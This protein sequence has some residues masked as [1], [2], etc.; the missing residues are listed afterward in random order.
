[1]SQINAGGHAFACKFHSLIKRVWGQTYV[2]LKWRGGR[3]V[4]ILKT[5]SSSVCENFRGVLISDHLSKAATDILDQ[6]VAPA[7]DKYVPKE[8]CGASADRGSDLAS[9]VVRTALDFAKHHS[10]SIAALFLDITKAFDFVI[11]ELAIG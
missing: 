11:R 2:P 6:D 8:Q 7:Y 9:H 3:L 5:G 10:R 1:M 4:E